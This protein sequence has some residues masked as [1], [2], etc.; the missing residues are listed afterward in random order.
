[1][2]EIDNIRE[3]L[4]KIARLGNGEYYGNSEGNILAQNI[5]NSNHGN[6]V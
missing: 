3:T 1:M 4:R 6:G 5:G 2:N